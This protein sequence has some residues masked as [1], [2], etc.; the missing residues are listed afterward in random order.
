MN[1]HEKLKHC[2]VQALPMQGDRH[3]SPPINKLPC[4][5]AVSL[6]GETGIYGGALV[7]K[8]SEHVTYGA[9]VFAWTPADG[10]IERSKRAGENAKY[11]E[12]VGQNWLEPIVTQPAIEIPYRHVGDWLDVCREKFNLKGVAVDPYLAE[13]VIKALSNQGIKTTRD[14][15]EEEDALLISLHPHGFIGEGK[16]DRYHYPLGMDSSINTLCY[17]ATHRYIA[18]E[19]HPILQWNFETAILKE[20]DDGRKRYSEAESQSPINPLVALTMAVGLAVAVDDRENQDY[21]SDWFKTGS[22]KGIIPSRVTWS[23]LLDRKQDDRVHP[24]EGIAPTNDKLIRGAIK[25]LEAQGLQVVPCKRKPGSYFVGF[26]DN[27]IDEIPAD[28]LPALELGVYFGLGGAARR[29]ARLVNP[30][31]GLSGIREIGALAREG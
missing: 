25:Y 21:I 29:L 10:I 2:V 23:H 24:P 22:I 20:G 27:G 13:G 16:G 6:N 15:R 5:A 8:F 26:N 3:G 1:L 12:W 7:W 11:S 4:Y 17:L 19:Y 14:T 9:R 30:L 31:S 28:E 18:F